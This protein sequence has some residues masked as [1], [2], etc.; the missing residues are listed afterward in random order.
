MSDDAPTQLEVRLLG[1]VEVLVDGA[2][3]EVPARRPR[4]LLA[5]LAL[6]AGEPVPAG[7]LYERVWG[8]DQPGD[9][10]AN[11]Y[12]CVRRLRKALGE[13]T[14]LNEGG[15]YSLRVRPDEVD[16]VRFA[17]LV[18]RARAAGADPEP[19]LREAL[20]L[21][22]G[23]PFGGEPL[24]DWVDEEESRR[25]TEKWLIAV[26][27]RV[28]LDLAAGRD[29]GLV[30]ELEALTT[31][32]PLREPLW[33]RY[34]MALA[35]SG[36]PADALAAYERIRVRLVDELG[37]DPSPELKSL[38]ADLLRGDRPEVASAA[39]VA[40]AVP[41]QLPSDAAG[42]T[43]R[44]AALVLLDDL[45]VEPDDSRPDPVVIG[46]LHGM[47]GVGKTTLAVHWAHRVADRFPDGQLFVNLRGYGPREPM[48]PV[49]AL[50]TLLRGLGFPG[51]KIPAGLD[52]R[53]A[54]LRSAVAGKRLL[55]V[56][57]DA[58]D[59]EQVRPLLPGAGSMVLVTSRSQLRGLAARDGAQRI[60]LD[61]LP[62]SEAVALLRG[63]LAK[64]Q[65]DESLV[66]GSHWRSRLPPN[67]PTS[68]RTPAC[69]T[70]SRSSATSRSA[71]TRSPTTTTS[72]RTSV[73]SS[74]GPTALWMP[75][76]ADSSAS[77][78]WHPQS[79]SA[80]R[81]RRLWLDYP[82][83]RHVVCSTASWRRAWSARRTRGSDSTIWC[84][85]TPPRWLAR[86]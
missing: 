63:R 4:A 64:A 24:S 52:T 54:L 79:T 28:D 60:G 78:G 34:L 11:L 1:R 45:L 22:R 27:Q 71:W 7:T 75:T 73:L 61:A 65:T 86:R 20:A 21:W 16:G 15:R 33:A 56:L 68:S 23:K 38:Y 66:V 3:V 32:Y 14:I 2:P 36:R 51:E 46:A 57:D 83:T 55:F 9:V 10:R 67:V 29:D 84:A 77:S 12:T 69:Q 6:S 70:C 42:F 47:G 13:D 85:S 82:S 44:E 41:R 35:R 74:R 39:A 19:L 72:W 81:R 80:S 8:H 59:A 26:Q 17:R 31:A 48:E 5:V 49:A 58:R 30:E 37:I 62:E 25:L 43:G 76:R 18:D 50:D 53:S 40:T